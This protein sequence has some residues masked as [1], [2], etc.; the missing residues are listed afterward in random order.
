M[1]AH[2]H[3]LPFLS[4]ATSVRCSPYGRRSAGL[5][6]C[7]A[8]AGQAGFFTRLGRLIQ[9]KAKSDVEKLFSGFSKTRENLSVVDE[10]LTYWNLADTDRALLVSDFGPKISFRI[11]DTLREEIRDGKLKSGA[12]IKE[13]LKRCIFE[14]LTSKGGNPE[15]QLG[16]RKPAVIM[17]V[18]VNGGGKTTSLGKLAYRF[19]NEGVKVL[20]AAGDTFRAAARDQLE[21]WAE[22]TG[23]EIVIDND[24]KAKPASVKRGKREGFDLV[25]CDTSGRLH[26]NYGLM[27]ELVS[28]K[29]VIAK[30]LPGAPNEILL[31]LDGTTGLNMLQQA[32][33]FN[34][35]SVVDELGIPVKFI[36]VGEGMED[37]QPFDAEAFVEAIFP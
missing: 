29:K 24:K 35:V 18:G 33:E 28:C 13:A 20:M 2:S 32:R 7:A 26:T 5:L 27:E 37:L 25:L 1:A 4:P 31:V 21:V 8:A 22:R 11:V 6:R 16:F 17:I 15:L 9:E 23:S 12:E 3:V 10:L 19:K 30:A 36:G 14:L 34:D